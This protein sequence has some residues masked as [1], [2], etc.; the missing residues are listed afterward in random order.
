MLLVLAAFGLAAFQNLPPPASRGTPTV[1]AQLALPSPIVLDGVGPSAAS[2]G[3]IQSIDLCFREYALQYSE[4]GATG[5]WTTWA[6]IPDRGT[7]WA[8]VYGFAPVNTYWWQLVVRD[9]DGSE[10]A[11]Q[12]VVTQSDVA[13]LSYSTINGTAVL[14]SWDNK[15]TYGGHIAFGSYK[16]MESVNGGPYT[17]YAQISDSGT[18]T[19]TVDGL[20]SS[21]GYTFYILTTDV[22]PD[23]AAGTPDSPSAS[24]A[25]TFG[26]PQP[27]GATAD[28]SAVAVD[29]GQ[30]VS[31]RCAASGGA[32]P[33]TYAW[34]FG[35]GGTAAGQTA[36][37]TYANSGPMR[38]TCTVRDAGSGQ[39]TA[40]VDLTVSPAPAV[41]AS[42]DHAAAVPGTD[43]S[44]TADAS[45]GPGTFTSYAWSFGDGSTASG[46]TATHA[47]GGTGS[48]TASVTVTDGNGGTASDTVT[49]SITTV[50]VSASSSTTYEAPARPIIFNAWAGGGAG[51]PYDFAWD[52]GD[53]T[54][55]SGASVSHAY[56]NPG[57]YSV[58]V[59]GSDSLGASGTAN[60]PTITIENGG[61][62]PGPPG[63]PLTVAFTYTPSSPVSGELVYFTA[64]PRGG[65]GG[66]SCSW[67]FGDGTQPQTCTATHTWAT[68]GGYN[69]S[70][71][72]SDSNGTQA[73]SHAQVRIGLRLAVTVD[74]SPGSPRVGEATTATAYPV[75]GSP[76]YTCRWTFGDGQSANG[77][78]VSH[79]WDQ[80]GAHSVSVQVTD[81]QG[82]QAIVVRSVQVA[83]A[84]LISG[85]TLLLLIPA[86]I[87]VAV[88]LHLWIH[89]KGPW[90]RRTSSSPGDPDDPP[91]SAALQQID[92]WIEDDPS[93]TR[94]SSATPRDLVARLNPRSLFAA[95]AVPQ[96][97]AASSLPV[98]NDSARAF[99]HMDPV[100]NAVVWDR[101]FQQP[102]YEVYSEGR[103]LRGVLAVHRTTRRNGANFIALHALDLD[104]ASALCQHLPPGFTIIHLTEEFPLTLLAHRAKEFR[105]K[106]AWLFQLDAKDFVDQPDER[107]RPLDPRWAE[108]VAKFWEPTWPAEDY[109]RRRIEEGPTAAIYE[110]GE[111]VAW[112]LTHIVTDRV[113]IIGMVHVLESHRR[114]G[115]AKA[116]VAAVSR[117]LLQSGKVPALHAYV[118]NE[119]SLALFPTLGFQ[120]VRIQVWGE[121]VFQ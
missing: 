90:S 18:T 55:G 39:A 83:A 38:A 100:G 85:W 116:V 27:I 17:V 4:S 91:D 114:K 107:V 45:G 8:F 71:L 95:K 9:C 59:T 89:R 14:L 117:D 26:A 34:D 102:E 118:D 70:V 35:D 66:Y 112:A 50:S 47:Y 77:C 3:W 73:S 109:V 82:H 31:F 88:A 65:A 119:A 93:R 11:T 110:N 36:S 16:V 111:P 20:S 57:N 56:T 72:A 49:L 121:A 92:D 63:G 84:G 68:P 75:G 101:A 94:A 61:G 98:N 22:C 10:A 96:V 80:P 30:S 25:V 54:T 103:P 13:S 24:N 48:F 6:T 64:Y 23:C 120:K 105:P 81:A 69:V 97:T 60:L 108:K 28:A 15:A 115:L 46:S 32:P 37:H 99:L 43:L 29:V 52:F 76:A 74:F 67:D 7:T 40:H 86:A 58:V 5:P 104:A 78:Q 106:S 44:F 53:G 79:T 12:V 2:L 33:Y 19:Y 41:V 62:G 42:V 87:V 21:N 51:S 1:D 113:G